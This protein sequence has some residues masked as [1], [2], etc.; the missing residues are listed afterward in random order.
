MGRGMGLCWFA[1]SLLAFNWTKYSFQS[2]VGA[3]FSVSCPCMQQHPDSTGPGTPG[4]WDLRW[5]QPSG[6]WRFLAHRSLAATLPQVIRELYLGC[7][8]DGGVR[9]GE[10]TCECNE[11]V[12]FPSHGGCQ[13][14]LAQM[15]LCVNS[16]N[17]TSVFFPC[18]FI[19]P[20]FSPAST[21]PT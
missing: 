20:G 18:T 8:P 6:S 21:F 15:K 17:L 5:L 19:A 11:R 16:W 2:V 7:L 1:W 14:L 12:S 13:V 10:V 4:E 3:G 9:A